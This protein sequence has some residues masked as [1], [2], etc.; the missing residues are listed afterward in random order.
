[1]ADEPVSYKFS[2]RGGITRSGTIE[3]TLVNIRTGLPDWYRYILDDNRLVLP[4]GRHITPDMAD[5]L[6]VCLAI[7]MCDRRAPR[8]MGRRVIDVSIP[9]R[10]PEGWNRPGVQQAVTR[11]AESLTGDTWIIRFEQR[12]HNP[13]QVVT[14][15]SFD[16]SPVIDDAVVALHSGGLDSLFGLAEVLAEN[17][18]SAVI[19]VSVIT[20]AKTRHV[21]NAVT[22]S[23]Q[24]AFPNVLIRESYLRLVH[25][26]ID[27]I[28]DRE[29]TYRTRILPCLGAG[30]VVAAAL[31][32]GR[33]QLTENGPGAINLPSS[34]EQLDAWTTR[35]THPKTLA[36]FADFAALV[37]GREIRIENTGLFKTKGQLAAVLKDSRFEEASRLTVSCERFPYATADAPCGGCM[38]C[39]YRQIA[40]HRV[41]MTHIDSERNARRNESLTG[42]SEQRLGIEASAL[43]LQAVRLT[44]LLSAADPY[45]E[46]DAEYG[47][48]DEVIQVAPHLKMTECE[49]RKSLIGLFR[50]F[51]TE[52]DAFRLANVLALPRLGECAVA[53]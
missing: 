4:L 46:L 45:R 39:L 43:A 15:L 9:V 26:R 17:D 33:L 31:G 20:H 48:I 44:T 23:L 47:R 40:L 21:V 16:P 37:L 1:M 13:R 7:A 53:S 30:V 41:G 38:S 5:L 10:R 49:I 42:T 34:P 35:A 27:R 3:R 36:A 51:V 50:E 22:E 29:G 6:D 28:D 11:L 8:D 52:I 32:S 25:R 18:R 19:P 14:Q 12:C 2:L 24:R